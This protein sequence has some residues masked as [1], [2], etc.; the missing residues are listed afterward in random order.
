MKNVASIKIKIRKSAQRAERLRGAIVRTE[1]DL[2]RHVSLLI[3]S[4]EG[5]LRS[6]ARSVGISAGYASDLIHRRRKI[7]QSI[8]AKILS[9]WTA[10]PTVNRS[11]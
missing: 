6:W 4:H 2:Q 3:Q 5:G 10:N 1:E 11:V 9:S 8:L 7:S